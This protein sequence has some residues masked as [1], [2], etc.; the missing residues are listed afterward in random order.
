MI[1]DAGRAAKAG[2]PWRRAIRSKLAENI[3]SLYLLQGLNYLLPLIVLPY[4]LRVI[5]PTEYGLIAFAQSLMGYG[6]LLTD[7]GFNLSATRAVSLARDRP[8]ELAGIF[9]STMMAKLLLLLGGGVAIALVILVVPAFR[10]EWRVFAT[11]GLMVLGAVTFPLWYFQGLERLRVAAIIQA[12]GKLA[13]LVLAFTLVHSAAD[14]LAAAAVLSAPSLIAAALCAVYLTVVAPVAFRRP[15]LAEI[16]AAFRS[17]WHL[18]LSSAAATLYL[19]GNALILGLMSG[20]YA[21]ALFSIANKV[22]LAVFGLLGPIVQAVYP[23]A[24]LIVQGSTAQA[25]AF[26]IRLSGALLP[27]AAVLSAALGLFA[28]QI[29]FLFGGAKYLDAVPVL[30]L[31]AVLPF[32]LTAATILAQIVMVNLGLSKPLSRIYMLLGLMNLALLPGLITLYGAV[33]A[34]AALVLVEAIGPFLMLR[35]I[36]GER[37][38][39]RSSTPCN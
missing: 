16:G 10:A 13:T 6:V 8:E 24:S 37:A 18:F 15:T 3:L 27:L 9:W 12:L 14:L 19:K 34:A 2:V 28:R 29:V 38:A 17:S 33:G 21:V 1:P 7:F 20:P 35:S 5:G 4:L 30:R 23:R 11:S 39:M 32:A 36:L 22:A 25:R 26:V 31:M